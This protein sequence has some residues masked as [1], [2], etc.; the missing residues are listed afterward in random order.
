VKYNIT[1]P[2]LRKVS[3]KFFVR[4]WWTAVTACT[5]LSARSDSVEWQCKKVI[6][7]AASINGISL[8]PTS[9]M[10]EC[11]VRWI[12]HSKYSLNSVDSSVVSWHLSSSSTCY[13]SKLTKHL[14]VCNVKRRLDAQ[15]T[16]VVEGTN[17]DDESIV[18]PPR[19]P[20]S[21][22]DESII[23]MVIRKI[24]AAYGMIK[25]S[26]FKPQGLHVKCNNLHLHVCTK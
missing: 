13:R 12:P 6:N 2:L 22:L 7:T 17:L 24:H 9:R 25:S 23:R 4:I 8:A 18:T 20:L 11:H 19:M 14:G 16:F 10:R 15:P 1:K 21:Q 3:K 26:V 5:L